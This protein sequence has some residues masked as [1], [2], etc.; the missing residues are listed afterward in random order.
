MI[1]SRAEGREAREALARRAGGDRVRA[2]APRN[3][4]FSEQQHAGDASDDDDKKTGRHSPRAECLF[5]V[6]EEASWLRCEREDLKR[7]S[8]PKRAFPPGGA[9]P[10]GRWPPSARRRS[11]S[12]S[13]RGTA[14]RWRPRRHATAALARRHL[15]HP[16]RPS[17][18]LLKH[19]RKLS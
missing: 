19:T 5:R 18:G 6:P 2:G 8:L 11:S 14:S 10:A 13:P 1:F 15:C 9:A 17:R 12:A 16:E 4:A 7:A 3:P